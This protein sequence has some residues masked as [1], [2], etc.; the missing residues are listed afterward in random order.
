MTFIQSKANSSLNTFRMLLVGMIAVMLAA[1]VALVILYNQT[2]AARHAT[3]D[4]Q[5]HI[6]RLESETAERQE[7]L[8]TQL[9]STALAAFAASRGLVEDRAPE[10]LSAS[11]GKWPLASRY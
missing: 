6:V 4:L 7:A 5:D 9:D 1:I 11:P 8:M 2:V 3:R 10:Y